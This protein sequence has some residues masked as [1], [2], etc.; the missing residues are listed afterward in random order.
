MQKKI[1]DAQKKFY[2]KF[3]KLKKLKKNNFIKITKKFKKNF[4][5]NLL[6]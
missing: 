2:Q 4:K 3:K 6:T 1:Y 5:K